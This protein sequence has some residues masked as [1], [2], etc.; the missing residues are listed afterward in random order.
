MP[1]N[2]NLLKEHEQ[3]NQELIELE[4]IM[5]SEEINYSNLIHVFKKLHDFWNFHEDREELF[6]TN[7]KKKGAKINFEKTLIEH[8]ELKGHWTVIRNAINSGD[9]NEVKISLDTDGKML[10]DKLRRHMNEEEEL[11]KNHIFRHQ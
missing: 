5:N 6:F 9:E 7:I 3:I 4:V 10:I 11:V 1:N 2:F 8:R